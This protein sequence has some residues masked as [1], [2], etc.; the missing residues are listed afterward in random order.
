MMIVL[1]PWYD[2]ETV[3]PPK[4]GELFGEDLFV[5]LGGD[6]LN[7]DRMPDDS[8][9]LRAPFNAEQLAQAAALHAEIGFDP[10]R[11]IWAGRVLPSPADLDEK[12][13]VY[14]ATET[15]TLRTTYG[16]V[17]EKGRTSLVRKLTIDIGNMALEDG[18]GH[19]WRH[20]H[21]AL[22]AERIWKTARSW[23]GS[24]ESHDGHPVNAIKD[25]LAYIYTLTHLALDH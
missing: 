15:N 23:L 3:P 14:I 22:A 11:A 24:V 6:T 1:M 9:V 7:L 5:Y 2:L 19:G 10:P 13:F 16:A 20:K 25:D 4:P 8:V 18:S 17:V 21:P 12:G